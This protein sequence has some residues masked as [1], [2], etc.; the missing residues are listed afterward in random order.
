MAKSNTKKIL[1]IIAVV[2]VLTLFWGVSA[3]NSLVGL[4]ETINEKWGNIQADYQ[5]RS[6]LIPNLVAAVK[7][8]TQYE[9]TALTD[10]TAAR[11]AWT[12]AK[13]QNAQIGAANQMDSAFSRLL[14]V[15]ESY[16]NLKA[17]ESYLS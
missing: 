16:P 13:T 7:S 9:G 4:D 12:S 6:D 10:I 11:S 2:V 15:V 1:G 17:R 8:Y 5:R 3:Y 14:A